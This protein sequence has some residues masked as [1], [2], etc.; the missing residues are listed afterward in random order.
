MTDTETLARWRAATDRR[1]TG[2]NVFMSRRYAAGIEAV[3]DAWTN[4][5]RLPRWLGSVSGELAPGGSAV[6]A[7]TP[8]IQVTCRIV[9]CQAPHRLAVIWCHPGEPETAAELRLRADGDGTI[10]ELEHG[11]LPAD[12]RVGYGYGWEDFLDRL[13]ALLS[14]GDPDA[15]SWDEAQET[16]RPLWAALAGV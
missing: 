2:G 12:L 3:W 4:P 15:I 1:M 14:G 8:Q 16:L 9:H 5:E 10:L 7:M 13:G 11:G 6:L